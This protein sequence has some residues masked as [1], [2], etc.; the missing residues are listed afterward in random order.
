MSKQVSVVT[1]HPEYA[2]WRTLPGD[3]GIG[4]LVR[5]HFKLN[6]SAGGHQSEEAAVGEIMETDPTKVGVRHVSMRWP[7]TSETGAGS[8]SSRKEQIVPVD[9]LVPEGAR[10]GLLPDNAMH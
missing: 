10:T 8:N 1:F 5:A 4:S 9:W 7:L 6:R 2:R 3:L